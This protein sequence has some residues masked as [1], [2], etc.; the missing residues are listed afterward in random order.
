LVGDNP[1]APGYAKQ[2]TPGTWIRTN[3]NKAADPG[4]QY[5]GPSFVPFGGGTPT[6]DA[7]WYAQDYLKKSAQGRTSYIVI[8]T[9]GDA[10]CNNS[11]RYPSASYSP[12]AGAIQAVKDAI[13]PD[14]YGGSVRTFVVGMAL[15][16][17]SASAQATLNGM[18]LQGGQ[19]CKLAS[20]GPCKHAY[21]A[22]DNF[23]DLYTNLGS[24]AATAIPCDFRLKELPGTPAAYADV[25]VQRFINGVPQP[26]EKSGLHWGWGTTSIANDTL[27]LQGTWCS[28]LQHDLGPEAYSFTID[29]GCTSPK[30][31]P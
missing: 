26:V 27:H 3:G 31:N 1:P 9:D 6:G 12:S 10:T 13:T 4:W 15:S 22:A 20:G 30:A 17:V 5:F 25:T 18:A 23:A 24:I 2:L 21:Y 29:F 28:D 11:T 8:V 14:I 16:N 7:I 19:Q